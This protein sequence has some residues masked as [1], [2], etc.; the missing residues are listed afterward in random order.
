MTRTFG[1][2][3]M[4]LGAAV[5]STASAADYRWLHG[6]SE[7][8]VRTIVHPGDL[9]LSKA[10]GRAALEQRVRRA[11]ARVC[12]HGERG[13]LSVGLYTR[14]CVGKA[15]KSAQPQIARAAERAAA[16]QLALRAR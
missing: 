6:G 5:P 10:E 7:D 15:I 2:I 16:R 8:V 3:C 9:D 12:N 1:L 4:L 14:R 11:A 13:P